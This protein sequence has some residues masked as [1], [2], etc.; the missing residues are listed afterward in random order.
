MN[1][2]THL[3]VVAVI[4]IVMGVLAFINLGLLL[5]NPVVQ[6]LVKDQPLPLPVQSVLTGGG[7]LVMII[8]GITVLMRR[9]WGR[10]LYVGWTVLGFAIGLLTAP[11]TLMLAPGALVFVVLCAFL[12]SPKANAWFAR[13][14]ADGLDA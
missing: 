1:R 11:A 6:E 2:P 14:P 5:L 10:W 12:F 4:L 8:C 7:A 3:I 9:G 13:R